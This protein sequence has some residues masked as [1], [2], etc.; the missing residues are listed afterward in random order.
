MTIQ[1]NQFRLE[2]TMNYFEINS[3]DFTNHQLN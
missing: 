2:K 1:K 3:H